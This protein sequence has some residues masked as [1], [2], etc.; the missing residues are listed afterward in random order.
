MVL[1]DVRYGQISSYGGPIG[2]PI[3]DKLAVNG[4][5]YNTGLPTASLQATGYT[6]NTRWQ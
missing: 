4:L 2:T 5:L 3:I 1:D 6:I